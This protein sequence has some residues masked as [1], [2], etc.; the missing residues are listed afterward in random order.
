ML[1]MRLVQGN[2][3]KRNGTDFVIGIKSS[4]KWRILLIVVKASVDTAAIDYN[5]VSSFFFFIKYLLEK[6]KD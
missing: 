3:L 6:K 4:F 1:P 2:F 5:D